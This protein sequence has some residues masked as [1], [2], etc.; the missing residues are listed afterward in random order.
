M[1]KLYIIRHAK[2]DWQNEDLEDFDR[3]L[4]DKGFKD[5]KRLALYL[6]NQNIS[7]DIILSSPA[8]RALSTA[9]IL[10][11]TLEFSKNIT[12]NQYIYE[13]FVSAIQETLTYIHDEHQV[14]I[15]VGHNPGVSS[16]AYM[17]CGSKEEMKT[18]SLV[19]IN[20]D[21][22]SWLDINK[23]NASFISYTK[24]KNF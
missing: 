20:F 21:C 16:L 12:Q 3:P 14:A 19:E 4:N 23:S 22:N 8:L 11:E 2:S 6:K 9:K 18:A 24:S 5:A 15:L 13:P 10:A 17:L 1:K 7:I